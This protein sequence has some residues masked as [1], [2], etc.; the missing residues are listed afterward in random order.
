MKCAGRQMQNAT[1][2][3]S[4]HLKIPIA[5]PNHKRIP[6]VYIRKSRRACNGITL[7]NFDTCYNTAI[8]RGC[9]INI[10]FAREFVVSKIDIRRNCVNAALCF[11]V[12]IR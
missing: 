12:V 5:I 11:S 6:H 2:R 4:H 3:V 7:K 9:K 8:R 1:N 10:Y